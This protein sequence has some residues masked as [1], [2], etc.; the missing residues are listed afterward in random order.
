M[1][2]ATTQSGHATTAV[3]TRQPDPDERAVLP[4]GALRAF[5]SAKL[6]RIADALPPDLRQ[7]APRYV[8]AAM[9][10]WQNSQTLQKCTGWSIFRSVIFAAQNGLEIGGPLSQGWLIPRWND[11]AGCQE[12]T[13]QIGVQGV[14][15]LAHRSGLVSGLWVGKIREGDEWDEVG[16]TEPRLDHRPRKLRPGETPGPVTHFYAVLALKSGQKIFKVMTIDEIDEHR[17]KFSKD[18]TDAKDDR[19]GNW[20]KNFD[21]MAAKTVAGQVLKFAPKSVVAAVAPALSA[22]E[23]GLIEVP[24]DAPPPT[25]LPPVEVDAM[26][27]DAGADDQP[28]NPD[29]YDDVAH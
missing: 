24:A 27:P 1:T 25:A 12:C 4:L 29:G 13:Y 8:M 23:L 7:H 28:G 20:L 26:D 22:A 5:M 2:P 16:G 19:K 11:K 21:A 15:A 9:G 14:A 3:A 18:G 17:R 10:A 6:D